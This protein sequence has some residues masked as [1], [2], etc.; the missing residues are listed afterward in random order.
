MAKRLLTIMFLVYFGM[1]S[2]SGCEESATSSLSIEL[3]P[4][5][6][7]VVAQD[8]KYTDGT[9]ETIDL[10]KNWFAYQLKLNNGSNE[11]IILS[12]I[13]VA[14]QIG[15]S[16]FSEETELEPLDKDS[17]F[18]I[19]LPAKVQGL[20]YEI[21]GMTE[22]F[23]FLSAMVEDEVYPQNLNYV[24]RLTVTGYTTRPEDASTAN[25]FPQKKVEK[26]FFFSTRAK[27]N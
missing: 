16:S 17:N 18:F 7:E 12:T 27:E 14:Y 13:S 15:D 8:F 5:I 22:T 23:R 1:N 9:G 19:S 3:N 24:I 4:T 6:P 25:P 21:W 2:L 20:E 11:R 26:Q 10:K